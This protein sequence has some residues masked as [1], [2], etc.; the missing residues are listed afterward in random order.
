MGNHCV[1]PPRWPLPHYGAMWPSIG[2][3]G[4]ALVGDC[5][6]AN[7]G[8]RKRCALLVTG[9]AKQKPAEG[10]CPLT[11]TNSFGESQAHLRHFGTGKHRSSYFSSSKCAWI[12][13]NWKPPNKQHRALENHFQVFLLKTGTDSY[14]KLGSWDHQDEQEKFLTRLISTW[15]IGSTPKKKTTASHKSI[16]FDESYMIICK[17]ALNLQG[18][19]PYQ[20]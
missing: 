1:L 13:I 7:K 3:H 5:R 17:M 14:L 2:G 19:P 15:E 8:T 10:P 12:S 16:D 18:G 20:I 9:S 4:L 11:K 6:I